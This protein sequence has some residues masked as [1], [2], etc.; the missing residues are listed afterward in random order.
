M[1]LSNGYKKRY[2][3]API[4]IEYPP[5]DR[6]LKLNA[7]ML[8]SSYFRPNNANELFLK[9]NLL[10]LSSAVTHYFVDCPLWVGYNSRICKNKFPRDRVEYL[11]FMNKSPTNHAVV[12]AC[13][14]KLK[15]IRMEVG[16]QYIEV[17]FDLAIFMI[18]L[19]IQ[20]AYSPLYNDIFIH[21]GPFHTNM[22]YFHA[23]GKFIDECGMTNLFMDIELIAPG[24]VNGL[25]SGKHFNRCK[26]IFTIS[27]LAIRELLFDRFM[28]DHEIPDLENFKDYLIQFSTP[29]TKKFHPYIDHEGAKNLLSE[30]QKF[31]KC[32]YDGELSLTA[33]Y[34]ARFLRLMDY[35][36]TFSRSIQTVDFQLHMSVLP[37]MINIF[38]ALNLFNYARWMTRYYNNLLNAGVTHPGLIEKH[39]KRGSFNVRRTTKDFSRQPT[40]FVIEET[41][42]AD[43]SSTAGVSN[44][45]DS[46]GARQRWCLNHNLRTAVKSKILNICGPKKNEDVTADLRKCNIA[47]SSQFFKKLKEAFILNTNPFCPT[48]EKKCLFNI[49]T[50]K[51][52]T[53]ETAKFLVNV[54]EYGKQLRDNFINECANDPMR[55]EQKRCLMKIKSFATEKIVKKIKI[56]GKEKTITMHRDIFGRLLAISLKH[57]VDLRCALS[58]PLTPFPPAFCRG[59]SS[60]WKTAKCQLSKYLEKFLTCA[61]GNLNNNSLQFTHVIYDGFYLMNKLVNAF[62]VYGELSNQILDKITKNHNLTR[63]DLIFDTYPDGPSIKDYE[64]ML[65]HTVRE[66]CTI[67]SPL[68]KRTQPLHHELHNIVFKQQLV[69]FLIDDWAK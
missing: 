8:P 7:F 17:D 15:R 61:E 14:D 48:L 35:Y 33:Q 4:E 63:V 56:S 24:S 5:I 58:F 40:D 3:F 16:Q 45:S 9:Y 26:R 31:E 43:A 64:H 6:P 49:T 44:F 62:E 22:A 2:K 51:P 1:P 32:V 46:I 18:A 12:R 39:F 54:E 38:F 66:T 29:S 23:I 53:N 42:N 20:H 13:L 11:A 55:F 59:D 57:K 30:Y 68:E 65:R 25:V 47:I 60:I 37:F 50:G 27:S 21:A 36:F 52:A 67:R 69:K 10:E 41:Q 28:S 19:R 34:Y